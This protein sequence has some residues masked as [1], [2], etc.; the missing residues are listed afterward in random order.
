M[1]T[2]TCFR[3]ALSLM[4][5]KLPWKTPSVSCKL[6]KSAFAQQGT[7]YAADLTNIVWPILNIFHSGPSRLHSAALE[8][9]M[10]EIVQLKANAAAAASAAEAREAKL[11]ADFEAQQ[12]AVWRARRLFAGSAHH[13][14]SPLPLP[15]TSPPQAATK[16]E[17]QQQALT[18]ARDA[19]QKEVA[20][21]T[22][23][24]AQ[25]ET[26]LKAAEASVASLRSEADQVERDRAGLEATATSLRAD[27]KRAH[28]QVTRLCGSQSAV[29]VTGVTSSQCKC[30]LCYRQ[31]HCKRR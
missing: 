8:E 19:A 26:Q 21:M 27:L 18:T 14:R 4:A 20:S 30:L 1:C 2:D 29:C 13:H 7:C 24:I 3:A 6:R 17:T 10:E 15:T 22:T 9:R 28:D 31:R 12:T 11:T 16:A 25:L 23:H 5:P